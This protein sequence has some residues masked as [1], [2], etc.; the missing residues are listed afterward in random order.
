LLAPSTR[1]PRGLLLPAPGGVIREEEVPREGVRLL[2]ER[3]LACSS[4]GT[5]YI[6]TRRRRE[7]GRG[8]GSSG[9]MFDEVEAQP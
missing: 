4:N 6:W 9:L 5:T 8:E 2:R 1:V 3:V 7:V